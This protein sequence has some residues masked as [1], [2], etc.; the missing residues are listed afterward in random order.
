MVFGR[1]WMGFPESKAQCWWGWGR[2]E[3]IVLKVQ[4]TSR[5]S[6]DLSSASHSSCGS[7]VT[8]L[9][10]NATLNRTVIL[11][12]PQ[13]RTTTGTSSPPL[14][15]P[16]NLLTGRKPCLRIRSLYWRLAH[17]QSS[18]STPTQ[19]LVI[20]LMDYHHDWSTWFWAPPSIKFHVS[21]WYLHT[22]HSEKTFTSLS[23]D[24]V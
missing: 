5:I 9:S 19:E 10:P 7:Y 23:T 22:S 18:L 2:C 6:G 1:F 20:L 11:K 3:S 13:P 21:S 4:K 15:P 17:A 8:I 16:F 24:I 14:C 12:Y